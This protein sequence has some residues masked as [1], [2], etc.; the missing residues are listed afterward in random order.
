MS[1]SKWNESYLNNRWGESILT[2]FSFF[3]FF[4]CT[5]FY[6][7]PLLWLNSCFLLIGTKRQRRCGERER[8]SKRKAW[9][10]LRPYKSPPALHFKLSAVH[11]VVW[12]GHDWLILSPSTLEG[13]LPA[14]VST[15][16]TINLISL[17]K[18]SITEAS[19]STGRSRMFSDE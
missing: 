10:L 6:K 9:V 4:Q 12:D 2:S 16:P 8:D 19:A 11:Y 17:N 7:P 1:L 15:A 14:N 18:T 3:S 13:L 5:Y